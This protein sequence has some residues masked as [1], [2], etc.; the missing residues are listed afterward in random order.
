MFNKKLILED[1]TELKGYGIGTAKD[2]IGELSFDISMFCQEKILADEKMK[3]KAVNFSYPLIGN[4]GVSK[5]KFE[6]LNLKAGAVIVKELC[7]KAS[8]F[9]N[10]YSFEDLMKKNNIVGI[11]GID[12]RFITKKIRLAKEGNKNIFGAIVN[13]NRKNEEVLK[14]ISKIKEEK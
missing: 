4:Y 1:G 13:I 3:K 9:E 8:N 10:D 14:E 12:T 11:E 6:K 7:K 5:E 2:F